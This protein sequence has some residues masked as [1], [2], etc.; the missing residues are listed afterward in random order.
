[1]MGMTRA[2]GE[3]PVTPAA[4][5]AGHHGG[6]PSAKRTAA[7]TLGAL[8]VV[9][10]DIGTN[11]LF[12]MKETFLSPHHTIEVL[13]ANV[14]GVLSLVFWSLVLVIT[15]KYLM[16]VMRADNDGEGGVLALAA[17][18]D[19]PADDPPGN[20]RP[21]VVPRKDGTVPR[22][23]VL[24]LLGLFGTA[25]LY[26]DGV[27]TPAIS[28]LAAVEGITITAPGFEPYVVPTAIAILIALF[29]IQR[30]GTATIGKVFGPVMVVW[31]F[32]IAALGTI[33]IAK[34]PEVFKAINP[35]YAF[36]YFSNNGAKGFLSMGAIFLVAC[37][38]E[39]LYA[40][41]GHFGRRPIQLG[42]TFLV[43]PALVLAYF[44][45]GAMLIGDPSTIDNP[46]FRMAPS[47]ML[48]PLVALA[49]MATVIASQALISGAYSLTVQAMQLGYAPRMRVVH[50]SSD[51]EGQ[52]YLPAVNA[53]LM[54][55]CIGLVLGFRSSSNLAAAY[56]LAVTNT[57]VITTILFYVVARRRFRWTA[58]KAGS[59]CAVLLLIEGTYFG[60][61]L[62]KIPDGGWFPLLVGVILLIVFTTWNTG[63][64]LVAEHIAS[65]RLPL[66]QFVADLA[67]NDVPRVEGVNVYLFSKSGG[68]PS[69]LL[70]SLRHA[71][72]LHSTELV[73][74]VVTERIP[75]VLPARRLDH[76]SLGDGF[77][78]IV[79]HY[80]FMEQPDVPRDLAAHNLGKFAFDPDL[81][82]YVLGRETLL[83]TDR[84][85]MVKWR[86]RLFATMSRNATPAANYFNLPIDR[87]IDIGLR[88]EL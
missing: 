34:R 63:R 24:F 23:G 81:A 66:S 12:A 9:Y 42:W 38:G 70:T 80:G 27:I 26:G 79:L 25:L 56:G 4:T 58:L 52:I 53:A 33:Q 87:V 45:M 55:A 59:I 51:A 19:N 76:T 2:S 37:G 73:V 43:F 44:G 3:K 54:V 48:L 18:T 39:A 7:L 84:P 16:F 49:T 29:A 32:T 15:V 41:M 6:A 21:A 22:I 11:V 40:D 64:R 83:I 36:Q 67:A 28:V 75:R 61:N 5:T 86:E 30:K 20:E 8:G 50:T 14:L 68:T 78:Q 60:A 57:M 65:G 71:G 31:F 35:V 17:L 82:S 47:W 1:M 88:V 46:T 77:H 10:G 74:S 62:F 69:A 85:G 72:S 13:E